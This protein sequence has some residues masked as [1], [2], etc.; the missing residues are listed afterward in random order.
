MFAPHAQCA[1]GVSL[2]TK[3]E[4]CRYSGLTNPCYG[5]WGSNGRARACCWKGVLQAEGE[6]SQEGV[7]RQRVGVGE[8]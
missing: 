8:Y 3:V 7:P 6:I 4:D 1:A 5:R 2:S